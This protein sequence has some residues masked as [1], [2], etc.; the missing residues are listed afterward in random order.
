MNANEIFKKIINQNSHIQKCSRCR[1]VKPISEFESILYADGKY[2]PAIRCK[3]CDEEY[4][5]LRQEKLQ[6]RKSTCRQYRQ[7]IIKAYGGRCACCGEDEPQF[8]ALDH[9]NND[10]ST[11]RR[12]LGINGGT[13]FYIWTIKNNFPSN[14][15]LLCHNCNMAKAFYGQCPH[16]Q[17]QS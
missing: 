10:G 12:E 13:S 17:N 3:I 2:R 7:I 9:I 4:T 5:S 11:H 15:Q 8:L 16:A 1:Q 6:S 14:L